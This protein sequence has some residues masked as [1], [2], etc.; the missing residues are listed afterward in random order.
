MA[1]KMSDTLTPKQRRAITALME[2]RTNTD[3]AKDANISE[4]QLYRWLNDPVFKAELAKTESQAMEMASRR[5]A[6][7]TKYALEVILYTMGNKHASDG[8]RL[9]AAKAWMDYFL[10]T[11][12]NADLSARVTALEVRIL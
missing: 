12:E 1:E 2:N 7:G 10:K 11:R 4:R 5:L 6:Y 8:L 3:A 9:S